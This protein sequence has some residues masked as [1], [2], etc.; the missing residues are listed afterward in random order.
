MMNNTIIYERTGHIARLVL[1]DP[2]RHNALGKAQLEGIQKALTQ[3]SGDDQVRVL[4]LTGT[5]QKTFCAGASLDELRSGELDESL[6]QKTAEQLH[7]MAVPTIC[8]INGSVYG[9]GVEL[10][11]SCDFRLGVEGSAMRVPAAAIG[12]CYPL[13]GI[14]RIVEHL[15]VNLAKRVLV[16]S[17]KFDAEA[18]LEIGF[19]D[20]LLLPS[21][22]VEET[23]KLAD[24]ITRLAPLAVRSMKE[25]LLRAASGNADEGRA[26][27]LAALCAN[28]GDLREGLLAQREKRQPRFKGE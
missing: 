3:A 26:A 6:F 24:H 25:I 7:S 10:A 22:L 12:I 4:V 8:A 21:Q 11:L 13:S 27:E 17:E 20:H 15:G 9:A 19:L 28:S 16:A 2:A 23:E 18:M 5:G 14:S 1:D